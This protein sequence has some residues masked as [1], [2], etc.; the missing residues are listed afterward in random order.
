VRIASLPKITPELFDRRLVVDYG[1]LPAP[2]T[3][4]THDH[5]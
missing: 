2:V 3:I 5:A 4:T 1:M